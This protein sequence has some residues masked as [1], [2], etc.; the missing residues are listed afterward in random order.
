MNKIA[1]ILLACALTLPAAALASAALWTGRRLS[2]RETV[3]FKE[4]AKRLLYA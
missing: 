2:A 4:K 3:K 1:R